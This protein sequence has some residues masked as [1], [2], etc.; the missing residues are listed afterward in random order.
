MYMYVHVIH[1]HLNVYHMYMYHHMYM[2]MYSY[3]AFECIIYYV[4]NV[5]ILSN[6]ASILYQLLRVHPCTCMYM[7]SAASL[8]Q[9]WTH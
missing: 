6:V 7:K 4:N 8:H 1:M 5:S 3:S 9:I 2:Y